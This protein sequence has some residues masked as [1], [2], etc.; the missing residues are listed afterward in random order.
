PIEK[1]IFSARP[2]HHDQPA[3]RPKLAIGAEAMRPADPRQQ[4]RDPHRPQRRNPTQ[5]GVGGMLAT[6]P[7]ELQSCRAPQRLHLLKLGVERGGAKARSRLIQFL[8][9]GRVLFGAV[10]RPSSTS[11]P[12]PAIDRLEPILEPDRI[13]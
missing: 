12:T 5:A 4:L 1:L 6:Q 3:K 10:N 2:L 7:R 13:T 11:N 8:Q 9:P